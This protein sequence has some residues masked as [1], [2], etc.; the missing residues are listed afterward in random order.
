MVIIIDDDRRKRNA[1]IDYS[2]AFCFREMEGGEEQEERKRTR[3]LP[4]QR[5]DKATDHLVQN[6][7]REVCIFQGSGNVMD[8]EA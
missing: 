3:S 2:L 6:N 4:G 5:K 1:A 7:I 8:S